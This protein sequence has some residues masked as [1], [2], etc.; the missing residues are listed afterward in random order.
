MGE[1]IGLLRAFTSSISDTIAETAGHLIVRL[2]RPHVEGETD[3][4]VDGLHRWEAPGRIVVNGTIYTYHSMTVTPSTNIIHDIVEW[5]A[6]PASLTLGLLADAKNYTPVTNFNLQF[7]DI[8]EVFAAFFVEYA[9]GTDL[10]TLGRNYGLFRP[11]GMPD[12]QYR[13]LLKVLIYLDASGFYAVEKVLDV[14]VGVG[15]Y[16][17]W[18]TPLSDEDHH[19]VFVDLLAQ[20]N[21][22]Y[23]GKTFLCAGEFQTSTGNFTV[24][25]DFEPVAVYAV[26]G[27]LTDD[28]AQDRQ[29]GT[30]YLFAPFN[31]FTDAANPS[32]L[33]TAGAVFLPEDQ[34]RSIV[35]TIGGESHIWKV[36]AVLGPTAVELTIPDN[37]AEISTGTPAKLTAD[38]PVFRSWMEGQ[39]IVVTSAADPLNL[40]E[41]TIDTFVSEYVVTLTGMSGGGWNSS[42]AGITFLIRA[43]YGSPPIA[44]VPFGLLRF[45]VAGHV[46]TTDPAAGVIPSELW[47]DYAT[48]PSA[49]LVRDHTLSGED[50]FPFYLFDDTWYVSDILDLILAAGCH[51]EVNRLY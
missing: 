9:E 17:A 27:R 44:S 43:N 28:P 50:Q 29:N 13:A 32:W 16:E 4:Y 36:A 21:D 15:N 25:A 20:P 23:R 31:G 8:E 48:I 34:D 39:D 19:K 26:Y 22:I 45:S 6:Y 5:K 18:D 49:Q 46:I 51:P 1:K 11:R 40:Q 12:A 35:L 38:T 37:P 7:S 47:I 42:D 33:Q 2:T 10:D 24:F 30:N 14:L 3:L 41:A